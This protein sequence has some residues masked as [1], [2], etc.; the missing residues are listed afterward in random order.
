MTFDLVLEDIKKQIPLCTTPELMRAF[1]AFM[2]AGIEYT[3]LKMQEAG[4][5]EGAIKELEYNYT[6][7]LFNLPSINT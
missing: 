1:D 7:I 6:K 4:Y 2:L 3:K 5:F